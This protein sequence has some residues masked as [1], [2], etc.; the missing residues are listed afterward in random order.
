MSARGG[1]E[2]SAG[3][4]EG[5][6]PSSSQQYGGGGGRRGGG[7]GGRGSAGVD[8][9]PPSKV[10]FLRNL[11]QDCEEDELKE[12]VADFGGAERV[13]LLQR[14]GQGFVQL[15]SVTNAT[16]AMDYF[17]RNAGFVRG[18]RTYVSYSNRRE[19]TKYVLFEGLLFLVGCRK[20]KGAAVVS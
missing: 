2:G 15:H 4:G 12:L 6:T 9:T 11:P 19:V 8:P 13:L 14:K 7:G 10:L 1:G 3:D 5:G 20:P 16:E 18:R 17:S